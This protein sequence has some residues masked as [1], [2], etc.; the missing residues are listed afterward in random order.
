MITIVLVEDHQIVRQ[1]LRLLLEA[2]PNFEVVAECGDGLEAVRLVERHA[3]DI[4]VID[5]MLPGLNGLEVVAQVSRRAKNTH[6]IVL[7]M[8]SNE[9]YVLD[10]LHKGALGYVLKDS[11]GDEL[12]HAIQSVM[13]GQR[14]LSAPLSDRAIEVYAA[15]AAG[16]STSLYHSLTPRE[17]EILQLAAESYT[18]AEIAQKLSIS[19]RT[20][21]TH[22][23]NIMRK[24]SLKNQ[25]DLVRFALRRGILPLDD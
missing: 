10:A 18:N 21:E 8:H 17:R 7:S 12:V 1:G 11:P 22:R 20:V 19:A 3:P 23:A 14:F 16:E 5:V 13:N 9:S 24:L 4:L 6:C 25:T 2:Q 15:Q